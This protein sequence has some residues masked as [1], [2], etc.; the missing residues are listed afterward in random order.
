MRNS[1]LRHPLAVLRT[2]L[3]LTQKEMA[4]LVGRAARTIQSVELGTM[5]LSEG[6][7]RVIAE[8]TGVGVG[9]LLEGDPT[10][11]PRQEGG[12]T[13]T[14]GDFERRRAGL[15]EFHGPCTVAG[16]RDR[17]LVTLVQ[18]L[19]WDTMGTPGGELVRW[20]LRRFVAS[21]STMDA[22]AEPKVS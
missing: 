15:E 22:G 21:L 13:Y 5:P 7:A 3:G 4:D 10:A 12:G 2:K 11:P 8:A 19:L 14:R 17:Q 20:K 18:G 1:P 9:W 16:E 6:L